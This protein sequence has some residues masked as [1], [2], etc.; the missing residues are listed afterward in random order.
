MAQDHFWFEEDFVNSVIIAS[1]AYLKEDDNINILE[2]GG[3]ALYQL[4]VELA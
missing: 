1:I 4:R 2:V 3:K